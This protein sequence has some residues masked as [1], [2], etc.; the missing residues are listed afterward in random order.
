MKRFVKLVH[1]MVYQGSS[2]HASLKLC[3]VGGV[4][5]QESLG[6]YSRAEVS[7]K[8]AHRA[9]TTRGLHYNQRLHL[10]D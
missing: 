3:T 10:L 4:G 8:S 7:P 5:V 1:R 6:S 2:I 9:R